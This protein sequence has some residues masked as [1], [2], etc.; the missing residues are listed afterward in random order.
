[1][2]DD[3]VIPE[4]E[5]GRWQSISVYTD[6]EDSSSSLSKTASSD[7][8]S[9]RLS[10]WVASGGGESS[11]TS[12][13]ATATESSSKVNVALDFQA[14]L[15]TVDRS[16]W[17]D[18]GFLASSE[19]FMKNDKNFTWTTRAKDQSLD[20]PVDGTSP[21][22]S[23]GEKLSQFFPSAAQP[24]FGAY[25]V[26]YIVV[27]DVVARISTGS[28]D[29]ATTQSNFNEKSA[30]SGG[31]LCFSHHSA[32][33]KSGESSSM[34]SESRSD[35]MIVRIPGPQ[36]LGYIQQ[37]TPKDNS[38]EFQTGQ[39]QI[40]VLNIPKRQP[41]LVFDDGREAANDRASHA[42]LPGGRDDD[43]DEDDESAGKD[44]K[45]A[46]PAAAPAPAG[47]QT[48]PTGSKGTAGAPEGGSATAVT[49]AYGV[50]RAPTRKRKDSSV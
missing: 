50:W 36:I 12:A 16:G 47:T 25:P 48:G 7:S 34:S 18:P 17:F 32:S 46:D 5:G 39:S 24:R 6:I 42:P 44:K 21:Q 3:S 35:G 33:E 30:S 45:K 19:G 40:P 15:V 31:F 26:G 41:P 14:T 23:A 22:A 28:H 49:P 11:N 27:K 9:W 20:S 10:L 37:L 8:S 29:G 43:D 38:K 1:M 2:A 13:T 4:S